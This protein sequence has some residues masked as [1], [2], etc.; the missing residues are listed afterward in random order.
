MEVHLDGR[1]IRT[2]RDF[3]EQLAQK[4]D[5]GPYYGCNLHALWDSLSR[6]VEGPCKIIWHNAEESRKNLGKTFEMIIDVFDR[7]VQE[8]QE[9]GEP[10]PFAYGLE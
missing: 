5:L 3:H 2:E 4:L 10:G 9:L 8:D 7:V 1:L 6:D